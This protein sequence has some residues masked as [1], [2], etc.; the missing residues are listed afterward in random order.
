MKKILSILAVLFAFLG[1]NAANAEGYKIQA[2]LT[3]KRLT[4]GTV[5]ELQMASDVT[6]QSAAAGD[7]FSAYLTKDTP[8]DSVILP[9]GTVIRGNIEKVTPAKRLYRAAVLKLN[10][11]HVVAP[12]GAQLPIK[13]GL[14]GNYMFDSTGGITGGVNYGGK[15]RQNAQ[16]SGSIIRNSVDWGIKS[17]N[18]WFTGGKYL[19]TP[20]STFGGIVGGACYFVGESV[21]DLF[22][23]GDN[24]LI[25][26][27]EMFN[28]LLI[29][30]IDVPVSE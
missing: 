21:I 15:V 14:S 3:T 2:D 8:Q 28:I 29:E 10:F 13:A 5:L 20:F 1:A 16:K 11:D 17:G 18:D 26:G 7:M 30:P 22:K 6:T 27:G 12:N 4:G 24:V 19:V 25:K 9:K 23:K